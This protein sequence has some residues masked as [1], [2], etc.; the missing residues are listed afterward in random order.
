M[1]DIEPMVESEVDIGMSITQSED[2]WCLYEEEDDKKN[3][4]ANLGREG[5]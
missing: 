3:E 2:D 5:D 1:P 4:M